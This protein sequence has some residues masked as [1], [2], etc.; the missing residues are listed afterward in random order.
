MDNKLRQKH[1]KILSY[2]EL[3]KKLPY[4]IVEIIFNYYITSSYY[5]MEN[6]SQEMYGLIYDCLMEYSFL[7]EKWISITCD[8]YAKNG[9]DAY[10]I[11]NE[12][13][14]KDVEIN[15]RQHFMGKK[16]KKKFLNRIGMFVNFTI[17][18]SITCYSNFEELFENYYYDKNSLDKQHYED[19][20]R[21][22]IY[23]KDCYC[24]SGI[25]NNIDEY[26]YVLKNVFSDKFVKNNCFEMF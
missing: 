14:M 7:R 17:K 19:F 15:N 11:T 8:N 25:F 1:T 10:S 20:F 13:F 12:I 9:F 22:L 18:Q 2:C 5:L 16:K 21:M 3:N 4:N 26:E 24:F 23:D 6:K